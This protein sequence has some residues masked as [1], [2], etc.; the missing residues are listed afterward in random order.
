MKM[1]IK[2]FSFFV[3]LQVVHLLLVARLS[4]LENAYAQ[5]PSN[6]YIV[7]LGARQ[8]DDPNH[9]TESHYDMLAAV[10]ESKELAQESMVYSYRHG[11]SGFAAKLTRPQA[12]QLSEHP[13]VI[14]VMPN[15]LYKLQTTR[16]W[17][18]L[19]LSSQSPDNIL[20]KSNMGDGIIIGVLD[21]GIWPESKA[22]SDEGLGTIPPSWKGFCQSGDQFNPAKH[23]NKKV[24]GARWFV[25]GILDAIGRQVNLTQEGEF[26]SARDADGHGTHVSST[27]AGG[28]VANVSYNTVG[29]GTARGGAPRARLAIYKVCWKLPSGQCAAA[30]ILKGLDEAIKDGVHVLS[31][32]IAAS[33]IPL[34]SEVDGRDAIA[35]GSFHAVQRGITVVCGA[36]N[37]GPSS[38][39]VKNTAPWII[40]VAA[41]TMDRSFVAQIT[42]GN[43]KTF[44]GQAI[45][46]SNETSARGLYYPGDVDG[47]LSAGVCEALLLSQRRTAGKIVLCFTTISSPIVTQLASLL[48]RAA[49]GVGV[50]VAKAPSAIAGQCDGVPCAEVDYE[51]G[52]S[53]LYYMRSSSNPSA[54]LSRSTTLVSKAVAARIPAFSSRGPNSIA[55]AI[56]KPDIA[57]P[58]VQ[59]IAATSDRD[60][61]AERGFTM[62]TG[63]SMS[64]PH[65]AGIVAL[66]RALHIE[67]SPAA[68]RSALTTT[69][70]TTDQYGIPIFAEGDTQK[71]A[72]PFDY[73]GGI[74]NP[75]RAACP[76]LVYDMD[77]SDYISYLC[78]MEYD[79]SAISRLT[80]RTITC[81]K[82]SSILDVNLPSITIPY[83]RNSTT[84]TRTVTNVG[85]V[86]SIYHV[87]IKP[88]TGT[89]VFVN[90]PILIFNSKVKKI[91]FEV[92]I[93]SMHQ[94]T[95][96]YYFG[97]LIWTDGVHDV[98]SP[99]AVRTAMPQRHA[100]AI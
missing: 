83:L 59:I 47:R 42:L 51:V 32:S 16:S 54:K 96:G 39:S 8:H 80:G 15:S 95:A 64:T 27:A 29:L 41:S 77:T 61:S 4:M 31:L 52:T 97:S 48:V 87:I 35:I 37:E 17:D 94:L 92:T 19:G 65:I 24:I 62:L 12:Q 50:I 67:W 86:N 43:N 25:D 70:W 88:P 76:G 10:M 89:F 100:T 57:A 23:C 13:D 22:F 81:P 60:G 68:I 20:D 72:D 9:T 5:E 28:Y 26:V 90:P 36:G 74:V 71:L 45:H 85:P 93:I 34:F 44:Q 58:G 38:Q 11:F 18:Y 53:I 56:L 63:T 79:N 21:T 6:V 7:Y 73:G 3:A 49:G 82:T 66:L 55:A 69:A 30:D 33:S 84:L 99:I 75:N 14:G 91:T 46:T 98:R 78:S 2:P 1:S 40:T